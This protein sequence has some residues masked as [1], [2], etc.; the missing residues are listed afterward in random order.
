MRSIPGNTV[1]RA[2]G[3]AL[4]LALAAGALTCARA[5]RVF[6]SNGRHVDGIVISEGT[7]E[8]VLRVEGGEMRL[9]RRR[10][11]TIQYA[12]PEQTAA[13]ERSWR[14]KNFLREAYVP[15]GMQDIAGRMRSLRDQR[16]AAMHAQQGISSCARRERARRAEYDALQRELVDLGRAIRDIDPREN[17]QAYNS[18]V[19][20][21]NE[22]QAA[23]S[24]KLDEIRALPAMEQ[25]W[26]SL[27]K[28]YQADLETLRNDVVALHS[29]GGGEDDPE[30]GVFLNRILSETAQWVTEFHTNSLPLRHDRYGYTLSANVNGEATGRFVVDTG[31]STVTMSSDF[32]RRAGVEWDPGAN[33]VELVLANGERIEG[34]A[35]ILKTVSVG[36]VTSEGVS[37]VVL[38][39]PP[40]D[41]LDGLLG[42]SFLGRYQ[43]RMEPD[44][45]RV[46]LVEFTPGE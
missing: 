6:L 7:D 19:V 2:A 37:A 26:H 32:A 28:A 12:S 34:V 30:A 38:E 42:M 40:A 9:A 23:L 14:R 17:V 8:V 44:K 31:A 33:R 25:G 41:N 22:L 4:F 15:P 16:Q 27:V 11:R 13:L 20:R 45:Q 46:S 39:N 5:D 18:Q 3:R 29:G 35:V 1:I 24:E 21:M 10:V 36:G 43:V